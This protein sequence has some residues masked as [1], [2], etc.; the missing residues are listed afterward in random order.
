MFHILPILPAKVLDAE[1]AEVKIARLEYQ[2]TL[3]LF[4]TRLPWSRKW[5]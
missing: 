1:V 5:R 3:Q 2:N 4:Q